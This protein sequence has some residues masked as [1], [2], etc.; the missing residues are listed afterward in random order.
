MSN[1]IYLVEDNEDLN[2]ILKT[3]LERE[4]YLV[5]GF[6]DGMS[7]HT[8]LHSP[9]DLWI[10]DIMLPDTTGYT[11]FKEIK[12]VHPHVPIIFIS[13]K[14]EEI[15]RVV[16]LELGCDDYIS[17]PFLP[18]ELVIKTN[19]L[20]EL[21]YGSKHTHHKVIKMNDYVINRENYTVSYDGVSLSLSSKEFELLLFFIDHANQVF[22]REQILDRLWDKNYFGSDRVVDD[23][24]RRLRKKIQNIP[25]E[26]VYGYGYRLVK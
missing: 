18:R 10:L 8:K 7:V 14:N 16:G 9:P 25:I 13:A 26:T 3:Y 22:S 4:G 15:D 6:L 2:S 1:T 21:T 23:T 17:K 11:L 5:E 12:K 20:I 19:K 24:V